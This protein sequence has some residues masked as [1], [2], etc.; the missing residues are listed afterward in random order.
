MS[1]ISHLHAPKYTQLPIF[2]SAPLAF[3]TV[4]FEKH[5]N[6]DDYK[7]WLSQDEVD[8]LINAASDSQQ[9]IA[10]ELGAHCGLR[11]EEIIHVAPVHVKDTEAGKMLRVDSA[12]NDNIRQ[13]PIPPQ[14]ATR[15]ETIDDVRDEP[16]DEPVIQSSKRTLRR[17]IKKSVEKLAD[18][19]EESMWQYVT[20]HDLRRTW[21]TSLKGE[22]VD[23]MV[24]CDW[25]GWNDLE[26]F[27]DH[28]RGKFSPEAQRKQR[29]K[30]EWL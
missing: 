15:L 6:R 3:R 14:L 30:V 19:S 22:D 7:V 20:M 9:R 2:L 17:W 23:A 8:D 4:F 29:G 10:F 26:T 25:G 5:D 12:K 13:T 16:A 24:V 1:P 27:L 21:A 18:D 28:Y 11:T